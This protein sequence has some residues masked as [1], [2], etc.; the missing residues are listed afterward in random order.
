MQLFGS[1]DSEISQ[2]RNAAFV[3]AVLLAVLIELNYHR[4][5]V[6]A[7]ILKNGFY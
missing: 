5:K 7:I 4:S 1:P 6:R 2:N 3:N